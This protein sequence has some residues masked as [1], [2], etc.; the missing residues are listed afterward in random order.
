MKLKKIASLALAGIMAVSMLAGCEGSAS[1]NTDDTTTTPVDNSFATAINAELNDKQKAIVTFENDSELTVALN[2][3]S[4]KFSSA[5][6]KTTTT[7]WMENQVVEDFRDMLDAVANASVYGEKWVENKDDTTAASV[8][9]VPGNLTEEGMTKAVADV[10]KGF[11]DTGHFANQSNS[12]KYRYSYGGDIA[13]VKVESL[14]GE[15][16]AY[17]V[18]IVVNQTVTEVASV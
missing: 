7:K 15:Y 18:G 13:V 9:I 10:I 6:L 12:T 14:S 17:V 2:A 16:S 1:S 8:L 3:I 5:D 4:D 11:L